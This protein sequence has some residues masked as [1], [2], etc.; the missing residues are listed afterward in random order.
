METTSGSRQ[1]TV[2]SIRR[3][4]QVCRRQTYDEDDSKLPAKVKVT[5]DSAVDAALS[6][7]LAES[8][9]AVSK[10]VNAINSSFEEIKQTISDP[11]LN[12]DICENAGLVTEWGGLEKVCEQCGARFTRKADQFFSKDFNFTLQSS[13]KVASGAGALIRGAVI[14]N[15]LTV[16]H[17][18]SPDFL[19]VV[20]P[21]LMDDTDIKR[22][23]KE[24]GEYRAVSEIV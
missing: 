18:R 15:F 10:R 2:P 4:F 5:K 11:I 17:R 24:L 19:L 12:Q 9:K 3:H 20:M 7:Q 6:K 14:G 1:V 21:Y 8:I 22:K 16:A 23:Q 13:S